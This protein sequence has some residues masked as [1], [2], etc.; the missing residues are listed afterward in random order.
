MKIKNSSVQNANSTSLIGK[1]Y[2]HFDYPVTQVELSA[3][4]DWLLNPTLIA[5]HSFY[6]FI[7]VVLR[8]K[9]YAF[10]KESGKRRKHPEGHKERDI[11]YASH[12]DSLIFSW[13]ACKLDALVENK[14]KELKLDK[15]VLAYRS[16]GLNNVAFAKEVFDYIEV[17]KECVALAFDV[18]KFFDTLN[19]KKLKQAW[20]Q[21]MGKISLDDD[22]HNVFKAMTRFRF[23][24]SA[25]I[26][27]HIS[28][29]R[30]KDC[31]K[32]NRYFLPDGFRKYIAPLQETNKKDFGIPQG[33]PLSAVL[34]NLY[35][36]S[37]DECL[38]KYAFDNQGIYRRYCDD[39]LLVLPASCASTAEKL[40]EV[41]FKRLELKMNAGK[42]ERRFFKITESGQ[43][44]EC[45]D[46]NGK[47]C[48]LQ[49]LGLE[50]DGKTVR[51]RPASLSRHHQ[52]IKEGVGKAVRKAFSKK[53]KA[54]VPGQVFKRSLYEKYTH[55]GKSNFI[56]YVYAAYRHTK[57]HVIKR[58]VR[59][60]IQR[61]N[62]YLKREVA[63]VDE[64]KTAAE[65][66]KE[67]KERG[68]ARQKRALAAPSARISKMD[69]TKL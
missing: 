7:K 49:Y 10:D 31:K 36:L 57:S 28:K 16:L 21:L 8:K 24:E 3:K 12:H 66:M 63:R 50:F 68:A 38:S 9:R 42:T 55:L 61:V 67:N 15:N 46:E 53:S 11:C 47:A 44:D 6:P 35:M 39:L 17:K 4:K 32:K 54:P 45:V 69:F 25:M 22:D 5:K 27:G 33:S 13:Y 58:Q 41:E 34:S 19:H 43:A 18:S 30:Y 59:G 60:S 20:S 37:L 2:L 65:Q 14:I 40:V 51:I 26:Q 23:V 29:K 1:C 62:L 48:S 52:R 64:L 56:S